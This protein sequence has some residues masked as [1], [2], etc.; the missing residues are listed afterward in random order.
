MTR[1]VTVIDPQDSRTGYDGP[2][3]YDGIGTDA[4]RSLIPGVY[5]ATDADGIPGQLV[6]H[7]DGW[8]AF[9]MDQ[10]GMLGCPTVPPHNHTELALM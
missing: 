4:H 3:A 5:D 7:Q 8:S 10:C 1:H 6:V 2:P 9:E